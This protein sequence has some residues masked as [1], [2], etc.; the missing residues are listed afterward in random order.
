MCSWL[1]ALPSLLDLQPHTVHS[2][3]RCPLHPLSPL[4]SATVPSM[5]GPS[6]LSR[7]H[8]VR[9]PT[10]AV[11]LL[12]VCLLAL[13]TVAAGAVSGASGAGDSGGDS[14]HSTLNEIGRLSVLRDYS[15]VSSSGASVAHFDAGSHHMFRSLSADGSSVAYSPRPSQSAV[16]DSAGLYQPFPDQLTLHFTAF[17]D[18][19]S[20]PLTLA[21]PPFD[22]STRIELMSPYNEV[23][24][25]LDAVSSSYRWTGNDSSDEWAMVTLRED[26]RFHLVLQAADGE[27]MQAEPV[28]HFKHDM[29]AGSWHAMSVDSERGMMIYKHSDLINLSERRCG[30]EEWAES[31]QS[32]GSNSSSSSSRRLLQTNMNDFFPTVAT[33][34]GIPNFGC[35]SSPQRLSIAV[36]SDAGFS[37]MFGGASND[38]V[39]AVASIFSVINVLYL[40]QLSVFL[41]VTSL[42]IFL[43]P[44]PIGGP[45]P[46]NLAPPAGSHGAYCTNSAADGSVT[47][48]NAQLVAL[49][50]WR[51]KYQPFTAGQHHL[52]TNCWPAPGVVGLSFYYN[53][54]L[55]QYAESVSSY[56]A[57]YWITVG[58]E[59][60]HTLGALHTFGEGGLMDYGDGAHYPKPNGPYQ[61]HPA[62]Q[63][64]ICS[65]VSDTMFSES[66]QPYCLS[67]YHPVCGNSIVEPGE[68]CDD[69]SACCTPQCMLAAG[70]QCSSSPSCCLLDTCQ[71]APSTTL[72][73]S[74]NGICTNGQCT[75]SSCPNSYPLCGLSEGGCQQLC[76]VGG[77]CIALAGS[78]A[79]PNNVTCS[80]SP[81]GVC[82][83]GQCTVTSVTY[84]YAA[85]SWSSCSCDGVQNRSIVCSGSDGNTYSLS[86]C[87]GTSSLPVSQQSCSVPSSCY[88]FAFNYSAWSGCSDTCDGG[89]QSR[90]ASCI[91][92][93]VPA[94]SLPLSNCTTAGATLLSLTAG[95]NNQSC[96]YSWQ[97]TAFGACSVDCGGGMQSRLSTCS[98]AINGGSQQMTAAD[99]TSHGLAAPVDSRSCNQQACDVYGW[100]YGSWAGCNVTCGGGLQTRAALCMDLTTNQQ[101]DASHCDATPVTTQPCNVQLCP[102]LQWL[103]GNWSDCSA[104]CG[105]GVQ[106]RSVQCWDSVYSQWYPAASCSAALSSPVIAQSCNVDACPSPPPAYYWQASPYWTACPVV[107]G[108]GV[109]YRNVSCI[110]PRTLLPVS[111]SLCSGSSA[112]PT[113]Q[114]CNTRTCDLYSWVV[115]GW[116]ACSSWCADGTQ[117]RTVQCSNFYTGELSP[118]TTCAHYMTSPVPS[119]LQ[120][121]NSDLACINGTGAI[122]VSGY[123][124][125]AMS[126]WS[127]CNVQC[128]GGYAMRNVS[129]VNVTLC[130]WS[131]APSPVQSCNS[132]PCS[133]TWNVGQWSPCSQRCGG[134][135]M[136]R[137]V[138]CIQYASNGTVGQVN[139]SLCLSAQPSVNA[140]CNYFPCPSLVYGN[141]SACSASCGIGAQ[142]RNVSCLNFDGTAASASQ[143]A[144]LTVDTLQRTC[145]TLPCPHWH[146]EL[147]SPCDVPCGGGTQT[148]TVACR[149]P[150]DDTYEG[151]V[152]SSALCVQQGAAA[153]GDGPG[154]DTE[155]SGIPATQ[156]SCNTQSC[157]LYYWMS[158]S[159]SNCSVPC[160]GGTQSVTVGCY[161]GAGSSLQ[162]VAASQCD[163]P[164]TPPSVI[165]CNPAA[166][167]TV[168]W[169]A[170][171]WSDCSAAC[172]TG[173][174]SRIVMCVAANQSVVDDTECDDSLTPS[175]ERECSVAEST[176]WGGSISSGGDVNGVCDVASGSCICRSG[177]SGSTCQ[178]APSISAVVTGTSSFTHGVALSEVLIIQWQWSGGIDAVSVLLVRDN[179][180]DWPAVGQYIGRYILNA[181]GYEWAVGSMLSD[182]DPASD[183]RV[184][185]WFSA[186]VWAD[187][188]L[189][190]IADPCGYV[191]CSAFGRCSDG[192]CGC[193]PGYSGTDCSVSPC[194]ALDCNADHSE[195]IDPTSPQLLLGVDDQWTDLPLGQ[196]I[197]D[198][199]WG[200]DQCNTPPS[201]NTS[202]SGHGDTQL[203]SVVGSGQVVYECGQCACQ[204]NW[205]GPHCSVC[206]L[207]C[208]NGGV[209]DSSCSE[210]QCATV[211]WFGPTCSCHYYVLEFTLATAAVDVLS[212]PLATDRFGRTLATDLS[213]AAGV[214]S[215]Q[216][217]NIAILSVR[218][219]EAGQLAV[220]VRFS[221]DC[222]LSSLYQTS[223]Q[224]ASD[225]ADGIVVRGVSSLSVA[226][227]SSLQQQSATQS[228]RSASAS[229]SGYMDLLAT[230]TAFAALF[231]DSDS[232]LY[233][234]AAS[235]YINQS[236]QASATDPTGTDAVSSPPRSS[237]RFAKPAQYV[238]AA[239]SSTADGGGADGP[240]GKSA[241]SSSSPSVFAIA[242][243]VVGAVVLLLLVAGVLVYRSH[244]RRSSPSS[245]PRPSYFSSLPSGSP[246]S[247]RP[248]PSPSRSRP[249]TAKADRLSLPPPHI[250]ISRYLADDNGRTSSQSFQPSSPS[251]APSELHSPNTNNGHPSPL[252][253]PAAFVTRSISDSTV[254]YVQHDEDDYPYKSNSRR[255]VTPP[256][257]PTLDDDCDMPTLELTSTHLTV[258]SAANRGQQAAVA[259]RTRQKQF[260]STLSI[261]SAVPPPVPSSSTSASSS[262]QSSVGPPPIPPLFAN[263]AKPPPVPPAF[264]KRPH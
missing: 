209:V 122:I 263:K 100:S 234:G 157:P 170:G 200:G 184:R 112:P 237:D 147:W 9:L 81:Y 71:Y 6:H 169:S 188:E 63:Q 231:G 85:S 16:R 30:A 246:S 77:A 213:I 31:A 17:G 41:T 103:Y 252:L 75:L 194:A 262:R 39:S 88:S 199:G 159:A 52:M 42:Q 32:A 12:L 257:P 259:S 51:Q 176:C 68:Q 151:M 47:N 158:D 224:L 207:S 33:E 172:G 119:E 154:A 220:S 98:R 76:K 196:C 74:N 89:S 46:W 45:N 251:I 162:Q 102:S 211:G 50:A 180:T 2:A 28:E 229:V 137:T 227:L 166:C 99:C 35:L 93:S 110:D 18:A 73:A 148:R 140:V 78:Y 136:S 212:D 198:A 254:A 115:S 202:C 95:C 67:P 22:A 165:T 208:G 29:E 256:P 179:T 178:Y 236:V 244:R 120:S 228:S 97:S 223:A 145:M 242:G 225:T 250:E 149:L 233:K 37:A 258:Q 264:L 84:S 173:W 190:T 174:Q 61:F 201:C 72:C 60:A 128:G 123:P 146:R 248:L 104:D 116:S 195:C 161:S 260:G 15:V 87:D 106:S 144:T 91:V 141:W 117:V 90:S 1:A 59:I 130:D 238:A 206:P 245:S 163:A 219:G 65:I 191:N 26:G 101:A 153:K 243:G 218:E 175:T 80:L 142:S 127:A 138:N 217:V 24:A 129:C 43:E 21:P 25:S 108:G 197:C 38:I 3:R 10:S 204:D 94:V 20:L 240:G 107:C 214:T 64:Q 171:N 139:S 53:I 216:Q 86:A 249:I 164:S 125:F 156:Q 221:R 152:V 82:Q 105:G 79:L 239:S 83:A 8:C 232:L 133:P 44:N 192:V 54:C 96:T 189:F 13:L 5:S 92:H 66:T 118:W 70:A 40:K 167:S 205:S 121:C 226:S 186:E 155:G 57:P 193:M 235:A 134:G 210:C 36:L 69:S 23:I 55:V 187:S 182:L 253:P 49:D 255:M 109:Q 11:V 160:G 131:A 177:W 215:G 19:Y 34:A 58:H 111:T 27:V 114:P 124:G 230:Y 56:N 241:S 113:S 183:Y 168:S 143:C 132:S 126:S 181:G 247:A 261:A 48:I 185:V 222:P 203:S 62:N 7:W 135:W 14:F 150:H 4:S